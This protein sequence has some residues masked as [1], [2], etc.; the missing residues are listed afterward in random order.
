[1]DLNR[2]PTSYEKGVDKVTFAV[3]DTQKMISDTVRRLLVKENDFEVRRR[4]LEGRSPNRLAL[5]GKFLE[6]GIIAT[7]FSEAVG[8]LGGMPRDA[9]VVLYE[10]GRSLAIEPYLASLVSG[11]VLVAAPQAVAKQEIEAVLSGERIIVLAHAEGIDPYAAPKVEARRSGDTYALFGIKP[12]V[13]HADIASAIIVTARISDFGQLGCFLVERND[14]DLELEALRLIDAASGA[15]VKLNGAKGTL[16]VAG[17]EATLALSEALAWYVSGL[18]A[19]TSGMVNAL[20][21]ATAEYMRTRKQFGV[22]LATFQALQHR[23][24]DMYAAEQEAT[25][26]TDTLLHQMENV[27]GEVQL[28]LTSMVKF[29]VDR[30]GRKIS[31]EAVQLHGG[32]GVSDELIISHYMRRLAC[33]RGECGGEDVHLSRFREQSRQSNRVLWFDETSAAAEHRAEVKNFVERN[34]P[35]S[36]GLKV[37]AGLEIKKSDY[38]EWEKI[39]HRNGWY[40]VAWPEE[41]GGAGWDLERQLIFV[42]EAALNN[43]PMII[44]YGVNM[45]GPVIYTFGSLEQKAKY[46]P[47]ILS[48]KTW[49]CQGYSEPNSGSDLA[50]L[51]TYAEID[52]DDYV[53]NGTKMWTTEAHWADMMH[54][55][56]RTRRDGKPQD[57]ITFLLIDMKTQGITI[58]PIITNEGAHHTNQIFLDNVR[59]PVENRVGQAGEGW[60]IAKFLLANERIAIADTGPKLRLLHEVKDIFSAYVEK[61]EVTTAVQASLAAKLTD[62]EIQ[63]AVLCMVERHYVV[64]WSR[65]ESRDGPEASLLKIRGTEILQR[66]AELAVELEGPF[67]TI[68]DPEDLHLPADT[69]FSPAQKASMMAYH[70]LYS[71]AWSIFGGTNEIQRNIISRYVLAK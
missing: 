16:L 51:K 54:C 69:A 47:D 60:K 26:A 38:V 42:Q 35:D 58:R 9:A 62:L 33:I 68:Y 19:E 41:H 14:S 64:A 8:G 20:I 13:R 28:A 43:A 45:V 21:T 63:L 36:I 30:A 34:L 2:Y 71:R 12:S 1:M 65:G 48:N 55:L 18:A 37:K 53:V 29:T 66:L 3:S 52:G 67:G 24:A 15:H 70:Y 22:P 17:D 56:V 4:R 5:W 7:L 25:I 27:P 44:P 61:A 57:G 23:L 10:I 40:G 32:M 6:S 39:L 31:H 49:W 46:L 59:I 50:S 11:R